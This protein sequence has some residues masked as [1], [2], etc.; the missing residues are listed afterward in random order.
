MLVARSAHCLVLQIRNKRRNKWTRLKK[1]LA[2]IRNSWKLGGCVRVSK[3]PSTIVLK[4]NSKSSGHNRIRR[5]QM[6]VH[7]P[8]LLTTH[9]PSLLHRNPR[10]SLEAETKSR[11][12]VIAHKRNANIMTKG[13]QKQGIENR[14]LQSMNSQSLRPSPE[15]GNLI[16]TKCY[17]RIN[18]TL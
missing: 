12:P 14:K 15:T 2:D 6:S 13:Y 18:E 16:T 7:E 11:A 3:S 10:T 5:N 9:T 4:A 1:L 17:V 8:F